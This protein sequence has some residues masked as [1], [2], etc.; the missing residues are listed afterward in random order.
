M[1]VQ[2]QTPNVCK[3]KTPITFL[4][5][6]LLTFGNLVAQSPACGDPQRFSETP[7]F[8]MSQL[9]TDTTLV[10]G[11][12]PNRFGTV[13]PLKMNIA[14]PKLN[15]DPLALR[16]VVLLVHG[17]GFVHGSRHDLNEECINF[18]RRGFV[19]ITIDYRLGHNCAAD[20]LSYELATYRAQQDARA[21]LRYIVHYASVARADTSWIFVG[22]G[23]AGAGTVLGLQYLTQA[24]VDTSQPALRATLGT[25][26][27]SGN[28]F[29]DTYTLKGIFNNWGAVSADY[30]QA[31]EALPTV[32]FHGDADQTVGI[33]SYMGGTCS[34]SQLLYGS[35]GIHDELVNWGVCS[36][37][38]VEVGGDHGIYNS[39]PAQREFRVRRAACFFR[40][41]MCG[42]CTTFYSTD[43]I[44]PDC[45]TPPANKLAA[46]QAR[47]I[48]APNP[49]T[50]GMLQVSLPSGWTAATLQVYDLAGGCLHKAA[51]RG[52]D[53]HAVDL[54]GL[55]AGL[56]LID[57]AGD[58]GQR[59]LIRYLITR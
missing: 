42:G 8:T 5:L 25:L 9:Y 36:D 24:E 58:A 19:A 1:G 39:T 38:T 16:P 28:A 22:G 33:D 12:A 18:A 59:E 54:S 46:E 31:S 26:D 3:M 17:G 20:P 41:V 7:R 48:L 47:A 56:Y 10:Y 32:A 30:F 44:G 57:L 45:Y 40:S 52:T 55:P 27:G 35:R 29:T 51:L 15:V 23:S 53:V 6:L 11:Q 49:S 13:V 2:V 37:L 43:S 14:F 4:L 21:A 50:D 34:D